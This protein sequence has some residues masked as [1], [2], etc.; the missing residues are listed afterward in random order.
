M[1]H[2]PPTGEAASL[3]PTIDEVQIYTPWSTSPNP[4]S[5]H[6]LRLGSTLAVSN[7][8]SRA[9]RLPLCVESSLHLKLPFVDKTNHGL[10]FFFENDL[11]LYF[12]VDFR[13]LGRLLWR[14]RHQCA[15]TW[16]HHNVL[17][18]HNNYGRLAQEVRG[19]YWIIVGKRFA[20]Y[21]VMC[22][23]FVNYLY[24]QAVITH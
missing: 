3:V 22:N 4:K 6:S 8:V 16:R 14:P 18:H 7:C 15:C 11:F 24:T 17:I 10:C 9:R 23:L 5:S 2:H 13:C 12:F 1:A 21:F 19:L 20:K